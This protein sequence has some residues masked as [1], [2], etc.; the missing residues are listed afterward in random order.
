MPS[1]TLPPPAI[2]ILDADP[3]LCG[4]LAGTLSSID[5]TLIVRTFNRTD[6]ILQAF[7]GDSY[8]REM[9]PCTLVTD[10]IGMTPSGT[11]V[12][13]IVAPK[14]PLMDIVLYS[15]EETRASEYLLQRRI[16]TFVPKPDFPELH[17]QVARLY[18]KYWNQLSL[19]ILRNYIE[20]HEDPPAEFFE[21]EDGR[22]L[23]IEDA[24]WE[25]VRDTDLGKRLRKAW[26]RLVA[27]RCSA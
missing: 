11:S 2:C 6:E 10:N 27:I 18:E 8:K 5:S 19:R 23:T 13:D 17:K 14:F 15:G 26:D 20:Q 1:S 21:A 24:Y 9:E 25:M 4:D 22:S 3:I 16:T 12:V 7:Y